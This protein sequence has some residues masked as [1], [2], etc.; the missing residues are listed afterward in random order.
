M[1]WFLALY[2]CLI[3]AL[4]C[5]VRA[6]DPVTTADSCTQVTF[7]GRPL[8]SVCGNLGPYNPSQ[9]SLFITEHLKQLAD[10]PSFSPTEFSLKDGAGSTQ[11]VA[12]DLIV[13][14]VTA[15]DAL[16]AGETGP[17]VAA[18]RLTAIQNAVRD[19]RSERQP[20]RLWASALW[21]L[22]GTILAC[23]LIWRLLRGTTL[24]LKALKSR[25]IRGVQVQQLT[26]VSSLRIALLL[27]Y[28][29]RTAALLITA[30][31]LYG[32]LL[33]VL[34]LF[35]WTRGYAGN[36]TAA[37]LAQLGIIGSAIL[38]ALPK[39]LIICLIIFA[40]FCINKFI[41]VIFSGIERGDI[42][43]GPIDAE[44]AA[45]T[46]RIIRYLLIALTVAAI[47]PYIPGSKS[48]GFEGVSVFVGILG[49]LAS[50][51]AASN[52]VAG[53]VVT[54]LRPF[55][56]GDRIKIN[57]TVG[58]V[59]SRS[60]LMTTVRTIKNVDVCIPNSLLLQAHILNYSNMAKDPGLILHTTVSIG[61][62]A[63]WRQIHDLLLSAARDTEG[64]NAEPSPFVLQKSLDDFYITYEIN[65]YTSLPNSQSATYSSL[66]QNI[67]DKFNEAGV[68]IM[69][70]HYK[71][72]RDGNT[73]AIPE[74]YRPEGYTPSGFKLD[75]SP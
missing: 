36:L 1:R 17:A 41:N 44:I 59:V 54:Y 12:G 25:Q 39:L 75:D 45:P 18:K 58:D 21:S 67:Q 53:I 47:F 40:A 37:V 43:F 8:F 56:I 57:D 46:H 19:Y 32:Y 65:V 50:A 6:Q 2:L 74:Q 68:E 61:Y 64:I 48:A 70:P 7:D 15:D 73:I 11:I 63:P 30:G 26:I 60:D 31:L 3:F 24:I 13:A 28:L 10:D 62:D 14:T 69:S 66:H 4:P 33:F 38:I 34:A 35:P 42:T 55:R 51:S 22:I 23:V 29:T 5:V 71:S 27:S 72:L 52:L 20:K 16:A 49:S 9:R